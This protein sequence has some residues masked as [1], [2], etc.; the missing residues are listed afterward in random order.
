[1]LERL[2][3]QKLG[4]WKCPRCKTT[5]WFKSE[6]AFE[7]A[8]KKGFDSCIECFAIVKIS[9]EGKKLKVERFHKRRYTKYEQQ[10]TDEDYDLLKRTVGLLKGLEMMSSGIHK[11][12]M[13][14]MLEGDHAGAIY[15]NMK[16]RQFGGDPLAEKAA[17]DIRYLRE[18][19]PGQTGTYF[20][21]KGKTQYLS[22]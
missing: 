13:G 12:E 4:K 11:L 10:L 9:M 2:F 8:L 17:Q 6:E 20:A 5:Q 3:G 22:M 7:E 1:M 15:W 21:K 19:Y 18:K 14:S 16:G